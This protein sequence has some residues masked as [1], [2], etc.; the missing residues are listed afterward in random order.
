M[1]YATL[2]ELRRFVGVDDS[3][4]DPSLSLAL[5]VGKQRCDD[6]TGRT[7]DAATVAAAR[8]L[9]AEDG[10]RLR[11]PAGWDIQSAS[12][13]IIRTDDNDD[14]TYETTWTI[15]TD[16]ELEAGIGPSGQSG[17]PTTALTAVGSRWW[18]TGTARRAVQITAL[19]GW[20]AVPDAVKQATLLL[21]SEAW[22]LKDA[23]FG[24]AA[25]GDFG[26]MR[27]RDNPAVAILLRDYAHPMKRA[28]LA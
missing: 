20:P 26:P 21:A 1:A 18:P 15:G 8:T 22:K 25:F 17:W 16:F 10:Y 27:V 4:D 14:G 7:F 6:I 19:W 13:L 28:V 24:V 2:S 5:L 12:G 9:H 3:W 23:P 11:L